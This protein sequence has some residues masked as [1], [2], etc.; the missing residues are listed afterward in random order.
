MT[1]KSFFISLFTT[2]LTPFL[3]LIGDKLGEFKDE[4][5][6]LI[7]QEAIFLGI[8]QYCF[9]YLDEQGIQKTKT[10][11]AGVKRD[12]LK[13]SDFLE[14]LKGT[15]IKIN[16]GTRFMRSMANLSIKIKPSTITIKQN[17]DKSLVNN[18]YLPLEVNLIEKPEIDLKPLLSNINTTYNKILKFTK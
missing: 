18:E 13:Y 15:E 9:R 3:H 14:M 17:T 7:I 8:K 1:L 6:G 10:V 2:D 16:T 4:L 5:N 11:F 12:S